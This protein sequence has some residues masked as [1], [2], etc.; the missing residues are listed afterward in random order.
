[1]MQ[2]SIIFISCKYRAVFQ[3]RASIAAPK[4]RLAGKVAR[5]KIQR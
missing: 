2:V 3:C 1:M 4:Q 5:A